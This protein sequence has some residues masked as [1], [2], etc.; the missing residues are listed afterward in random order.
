MIFEES[1]IISILIPFLIPFFIIFSD[2]GT[3]N[4]LY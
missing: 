1:V 4:V 2:W 3:H